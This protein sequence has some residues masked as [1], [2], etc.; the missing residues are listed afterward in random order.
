LCQGHWI[1]CFRWASISRGAAIRSTGYD[2]HNDDQ[3]FPVVTS[4]ISKAHYGMAFKEHFDSS[5]HTDE[6]RREYDAAK[7]VDLV[8][9]Q[10]RWYVSKVRFASAQFFRSE[11]DEP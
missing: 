2:D 10:M 1:E 8:W 11:S 7:G 5:R 6:D 3:P 4:Y 9:D